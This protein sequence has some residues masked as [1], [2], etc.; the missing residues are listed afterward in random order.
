[1]LVKEKDATRAHDALASE[2]RRLPMTEITKE[3][4]FD[5]PDGP[6]TLLDL[7]AGRRQLIVYHFMFAPGWDEGCERSSFVVDN[8][9]HLAHLHARNTSLTLVSRTPMAEIVP[10][11]NR[12]G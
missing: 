8:I 5:G 11:N 12:M 10:F 2:R 4:V 1:L 9:G 3:Y 6:V 7:F